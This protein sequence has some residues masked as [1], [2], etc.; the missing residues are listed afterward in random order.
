M[1][2]SDLLPARVTIEFQVPLT[3]TATGPIPG[4]ERPTCI[5]RLCSPAMSIF[6]NS[7][8]VWGFVD[9]MTSCKAVLVWEKSPGS[10]FPEKSPA[11]IPRRTGR[12]PNANRS[13]AWKSRLCW[14]QT[15]RVLF[16]LPFAFDAIPGVRNYP[17]PRLGDQ[18]FRDSTTGLLA[19]GTNPV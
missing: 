17:Q 15:L 3:N 16:A 2:S 14:L 9:C 19:A 10:T 1:C 7:Q 11:F 8:C 18:G 4:T 6:M 12:K 5:W 13:G